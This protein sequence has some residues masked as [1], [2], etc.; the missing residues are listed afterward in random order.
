MR[1]DDEC[2][3]FTDPVSI[4]V[5]A[6][7]TYATSRRNQCE[8][9]LRLLRDILGLQEKLVEIPRNFIDRGWEHAVNYMELCGCFYIGNWFL[10]LGLR[11]A[12]FRC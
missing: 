1:W 3:A 4:V 12:V 7:K 2:E 8:P 5:V 6:A 10:M 11:G 9:A